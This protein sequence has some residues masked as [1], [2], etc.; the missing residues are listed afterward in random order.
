MAEL[1][2]QASRDCV[3]MEILPAGTDSRVGMVFL[4]LEGSNEKK[5]RIKF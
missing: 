1:P 5:I 2:S 4:H 3:Q